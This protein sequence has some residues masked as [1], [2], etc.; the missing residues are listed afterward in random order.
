MTPLMALWWPS[1]KHSRKVTMMMVVSSSAYLLT[2]VTFTANTQRNPLSIL[3]VH[4]RQ[5]LR[6][7]DDG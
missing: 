7:A 2:A 6:P 4:L 1:K 3:E 5:P